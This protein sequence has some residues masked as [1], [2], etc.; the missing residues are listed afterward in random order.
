[1]RT[2]RHRWATLLLAVALLAGCEAPPPAAPAPKPVDVAFLRDL[3]AWRQQR[4]QD[5]QRPGG[6]TSLIGLHWLDPGAHYAG[7][8]RRNGVRLAMG[9]PHLGMFELR[10]ERVRF[11]PERGVALTLDGAPLRGEAWLRSDADPQGASVI[12]FDDGKGGVS[13]VRRGSRHALRVWHADAPSRVNFAGLSTWPADPAWRL[14]AKLVTHPPGR[15]LEIHDIVG[16]TIAAANP[17]RVEFVRDGRT[18]SLEMVVWGGESL[19]MFADATNAKGSFSAGRYVLV[20]R[21][22]EATRIVVDFNRAYNPPCAFT[23][24]TA[25]PLPPLANR[26]DLAVTAGEK[27]YVPRRT[28]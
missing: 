15:T 5:L 25:C 1:M 19:L 21:P 8:D 20:E 10:G 24:Y 11:V 27:A 23:P 18:F 22:R 14:D 16:N 6:W 9:P 7:S 17:A 3:Q 26:L 4:L 12:G 13:V 28:F 2:H